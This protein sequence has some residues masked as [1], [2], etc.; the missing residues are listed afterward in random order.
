[1]W[2]K[3]NWWGYVRK[4]FFTFHVS[5]VLLQQQYREKG[6]KRYFE[7]IACLLLAEQNNKLLLKNHE[8]WPTGASPFLKMNVTQSSHSRRDS[9][10]GRGHGRGRGHG[11]DHGKYMSYHHD[12]NYGKKQNIRQ[13]SVDKKNDEK[14][15]YEDKCYKCSIEGHWSHTYCTTEYLVELYQASLKRKNKNVKTNFIDQK[16]IRDN[17]DIYANLTHFD[18]ANFFAHSEDTKWLSWRCKMMWRIPNECLNFVLFI[19]FASFM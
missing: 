9:G 7:L 2:W 13:K 5:N 11:W 4:L 14:K 8:F 10:C 3:C 19:I 6:F 1:M 15:N 18:V 16:N 12:H 17:N